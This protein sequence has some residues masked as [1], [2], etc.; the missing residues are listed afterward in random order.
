MHYSRLLG[1]VRLPIPHSGPFPI[2][3][4]FHYLSSYIS[5]KK[6]FTMKQIFPF[7]GLLIFISFSLVSCGSSD[8][9][10]KSLAFQTLEERYPAWSNLTWVST[11]RDS[12]AF[13]RMEITIHE[14]VITLRQHTSDTASIAHE[15]STMFFLGNTLT[16][17]DKN[18][19]SLTGFYRLTDST[20][21]IRT[22]GLLD[23]YPEEIHN[24]LM[25]I[26]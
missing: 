14:N 20:I 12:G 7:I 13:P 1:I 26:H 6:N 24:Y 5:N 18:K 16:F 2:F 23:G 9:N 21:M 3:I 17:E 19:S 11:D 8:P 22:Q 4:Y 15:Y 25:L 10:K